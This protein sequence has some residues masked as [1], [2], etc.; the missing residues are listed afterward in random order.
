[1]RCLPYA[2][3]ISLASIDKGSEPPQG[4]FRARSSRPIAYSLSALFARARDTTPAIASSAPRPPTMASSRYAIR[5]SVITKPSYVSC[6]IVGD[7]I[8]CF[9]IKRIGQTDDSGRLST[10]KQCG[11]G[12]GRGTRR[13][14]RKGSCRYRAMSA[15][16]QPMLTSC[17]PKR[18]WHSL[19]GSASC[20]N[21]SRFVA[22]CRFVSSRI[23]FMP[24]EHAAL[25]ILD[26]ART[27]GH[28]CAF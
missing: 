1:M 26:C 21:W 19:H 24:H 6:C 10:H 22:F 8:G 20:M 18:A 17:R 5:N 11:C 25:G 15:V 3:G 27:R 7:L 13:R 23:S 16:S 14:L 9:G 2:I 12:G 28:R 4:R